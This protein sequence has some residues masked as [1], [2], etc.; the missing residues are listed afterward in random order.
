MA[1][2]TKAKAKTKAKTTQTAKKALTRAQGPGPKSKK[3]PA[4]AKAPA[5]GKPASTA[6]LT[7]KP[8]AKPVSKCVLGSKDLEQFKAVLLRMRE[9]L[10]GQ[11]NALSDDSLKYIDDSSS[12]DRTDDFDREFA[13]NLVSSEHDAVFDIDEALRRIEER[14]YGACDACGQ[15]IERGRLQAL[16]FARM[17]VRCQSDAE[18]GRSRFRPFGDTLSQGSE[19]STETAEAEEAE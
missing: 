5:R 4:A 8:A 1:T 11:I 17:C 13:L 6:K 3:T 15:A 10:T 16:P 7:V 19:P 14:T 12:E 18:R 9:R 2:K